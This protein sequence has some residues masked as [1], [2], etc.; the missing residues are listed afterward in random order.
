MQPPLTLD[1]KAAPPRFRIADLEVDL[2][3]AEVTRGG[4]QIALPKLSFDLLLALINAAPSIVTNEELLQQVWPGLLVSPESVAQRVKLLR[5]AIGDDSQQPRYILGV[6]G[7]GYRLIPVPERLEGSRPLTGDATNLS[8]SMPS[9]AIPEAAGQ[10]SDA[11]SQAVPPPDA[12]GVGKRVGVVAA[13]VL[14]AVGVAVVLGWRYWSSSHQDPQGSVAMADKSIAVLPFVDMSEKKDQEYFGDGMAE[15]IID[16]LAKIPGLRVIGR[17]S[18]FQFK[19]KTEDLRSIAKQL[20]VAMVLEG[21]VRKSGDRM[22]V[23]AQLIDSRTGTPRWSE[24]YDRDFIEVLKLQDEIAIRVAREVETDAFISEFVS[25]RALRNPEAYTAFLQGLLADER[26]DQQSGEQAVSDFQRALDLDP[27]FADAASSLA[28]AYRF[29]GN[30]GF[31]PPAAAYEKA[32]NAA[33]LAL[34]LDP[35]QSEAHAVLGYIHIIHDWDW[36]AAEREIKLAKTLALQGEDSTVDSAV[37]SMTLGHWDEALSIVNSQVAADPLWATGYFWLG[38]LQLRRGRFPE[39]EAAMRRTSELTPTYTYLH[40]ALALVRLA[41]GDPEAALAESLQEP[42]D[43]GRLGGSALAY[44]ALGR[45]S[46]SDAALAQAL[47]TYAP[48]IPSGIA[49]VYAFRG[50]SDEAFKWLERAYAQKDPLLYR[51]NFTTEFDKLHDDPRYKAFL[52]KMNLPDP[53]SPRE[54]GSITSEPGNRA[55]TGDPPR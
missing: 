36:P 51:I 10:G 17:T 46:E 4:E 18:S 12:G 39:A 44:F 1:S 9:L 47:R 40:Y 7:R 48:Y 32:R 54:A 29:L 14:L 22:R 3:K 5:A 13:A 6:R 31:M 11:S 37:L 25:R 28:D 8:V 35:S 20:G 55:L 30:F 16:L 34:K 26:A 52:K 42:S 21:S 50:E 27:Q 41:R 53:A 19:G 49:A 38:I 45:R 24:S 23:T 43:A 33:D 15:E 2:G